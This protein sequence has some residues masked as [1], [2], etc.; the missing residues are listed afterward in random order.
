MKT[1]NGK[2]FWVFDNLGETLD[3]YTIVTHDADICGASENPFQGFGQFSHNLCDKYSISY[4]IEWRKR[5]DAG[6][7]I[8]SEIKDYLYEMR[9]PKNSL[10]KEIKSMKLLPKNLVQYIEQINQ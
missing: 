8:K 3:R 9:R 2:Q 6:K 5:L 7:I 10:G 4:G 1:S